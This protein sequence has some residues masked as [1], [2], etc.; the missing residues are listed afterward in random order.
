M[1]Q[2]LTLLGQFIRLEPLSMTHWA[3]LCEVGL[4]DRIWQWT[5]PWVRTPEEMRAMIENALKQ[6]LSGNSLPFATIDLAAGR[7]VGSTGFLNYSA[8]DR[9]VEIGSTWLGVA[10][11]STF[12]NTEAK[13]LMLGHAF[14]TLGVQRVEFQTDALN[15]RSRAAI[16][17]LGARQEGI[18]RKH[19]IMPGGRVRDS[20][21]F[22]LLDDEWPAAK[23]AAKAALEKR[24]IGG[25]DGNRL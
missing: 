18:L 2:P 4:D 10:W 20:V 22:S 3:D 11:Q 15:E 5:H 12:V 13:Y 24:L 25:D 6:Q 23:A 19:R 17:R 7:A 8:A 9:H 1:L 14:E 21:V 16:P